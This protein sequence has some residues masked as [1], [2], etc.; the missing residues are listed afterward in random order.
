MIRHLRLTDLPRQ[1]LPGGLQTEDLAQTRS[2]LAAPTHHLTPLQLAR[3]SLSSSKEQHPLAAVRNGTLGALALLHARNGPRAWEVAHL[4]GNGAAMEE[5]QSVLE[6]SVAYIGSR[7]GERLFLR[8]LHRSP[9]QDVAQRAGFFPAY[10]EEVFSLNRPMFADTSLPPFHIRPP[11]PVD[12]YAL[13]R[14]YN[15]AL[16]SAARAAAGLTFDQWQDAREA[17]QGMA[18]EYV[19]E[20]EGRIRGWVRFD[21][22]GDVLSIEAML[23]PEEGV[24]APLLV[25]H[26]A[27]FA[28]GHARAV[29][30]VPSF[31]PAIAHTLAS[32]AWTPS[33]NY[34]VLIRS[35]AIPAEEPALM[36]ARA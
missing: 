33:G 12:A 28:W 23:H 14:L 31:Q 8:V 4:F 32:R 25:G 17:A 3:W 9:V 34:A 18:R 11:L 15:A 24:S 36:P 29:W 5:L 21:Q 35:A 20:K 1:L 7:G 6:Q 22:T 27:H 19:W 2:E 10:T 16:P 13:F 30:I 26:A